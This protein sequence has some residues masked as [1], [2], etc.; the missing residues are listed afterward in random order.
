MHKFRREYGYEKKFKNAIKKV[1]SDNLLM[2]STSFFSLY[3]KP[4]TLCVAYNTLTKEFI[5]DEELNQ[6]LTKIKSQVEDLNVNI[7]G[8]TFDINTQL[9]TY[10]FKEKALEIST[11]NIDNLY[12]TY[13]NYLQFTPTPIKEYGKPAV[14]IIYYDDLTVLSRMSNKGFI[15]TPFKF[16]IDFLEN[17]K[18][19]IL[20]LKEFQLV[21]DL[22]I[23]SDLTHYHYSKK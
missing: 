3:L 15:P 1:I 9:I 12:K 7:K 2:D 10:T 23:E 4:D 16:N 17:D 20:K 13:I 18:S 8:L 19:F 14:R 6:M 22:K 5:S 11:Y 21:K